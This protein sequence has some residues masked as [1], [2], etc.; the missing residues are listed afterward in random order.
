MSRVDSS[1]LGAMKARSP[2]EGAAMASDAFFPF[3]DGI[4]AAAEV[5]VRAVVQPGG[6]IRDEEVVAAANEHG[7]A[8]VF[9]GRRH[10]RH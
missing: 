10:F 5:G 6:S 1:K 3:R 2:L 7:M 9:T 8:M 4:D